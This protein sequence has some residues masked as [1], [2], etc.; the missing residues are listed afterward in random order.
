VALS[1]RAILLLGPTVDLGLSG[2]TSFTPGEGGT[3][4]VRRNIKETDVGLQA[5]FALYF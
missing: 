1:P 4:S 3:A 2:S 5:S